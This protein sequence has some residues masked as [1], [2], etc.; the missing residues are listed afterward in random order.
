[1][2]SILQKKFWRIFDIRIKHLRFLLLIVAMEFYFPS[3][4]T[5]LVKFWTNDFIIIF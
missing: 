3:T 5:K 1:M 4:E 2:R